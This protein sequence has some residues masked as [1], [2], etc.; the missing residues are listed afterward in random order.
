[1]I[2]SSCKLYNILPV[3]FLDRNVFL[4]MSDEFV[5]RT[6]NLALVHKLLDPVCRPAGDTGDCKNR[7]EDLNRQL[8]HRID[9]ST[10]EINICTDGLE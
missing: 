9:E 1:M 4:M 5:S 7:C 2:C 10:V 6:D 8:Q 3:S